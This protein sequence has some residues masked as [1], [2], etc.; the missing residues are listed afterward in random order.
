MNSLANK[1]LENL[2]GIFGLMLALTS[3]V[4]GMPPLNSF[5]VYTT[6][7]ALV[8]GASWGVLEFTEDTATFKGN[9]K[10]EGAT[11]V[12]KPTISLK[13]PKLDPDL[14]L[15]I[16]TYSQAGFVMAVGDR[17]GLAYIIGEKERPARMNIK[18]LDGGDK[19]GDYNG[20]TI[21]LFAYSTYPLRHCAVQ[22]VPPSPD[23]RKV[24]SSGFSFGFLR[25]P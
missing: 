7:P 19:V 2:S 10:R 25:T 11:T 9:P 23:P 1:H 8:D 16:D 3:E 12:Y 13:A 5:G 22:I 18:D 24:F 4:M 14:S 21:D 20:A 15:F 6:L 17:N